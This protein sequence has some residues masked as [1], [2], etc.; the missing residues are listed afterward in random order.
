MSA[1]LSEYSKKMM[2]YI[3]RP[4]AP[5]QPG[6]PATPQSYHLN[7][8]NSKQQGLLRLEERYVKKYSKF[9]RI[10]DRLV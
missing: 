3:S 6:Q 2:S 10:S 5:P 1:I 9:S 8:I 7:V 4:S